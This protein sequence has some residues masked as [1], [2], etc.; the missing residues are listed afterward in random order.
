MIA[1]LVL[2][3]LAVSAAAG[4]FAR[5]FGYDPEN[6]TKCLQS[7]I[8]SGARTVIVDAAPGT[9]FIEPIRLRSDLE[10]V[11]GEGVT[12]RAVPGA[13]K[14]IYSMMFRGD[15]VTNVTI[16]GERGATLSMLKRD[17]LDAERYR[18]S[19]WRHMLAFYDSGRIAVSN[20]T[21]S[22]SGGDG[23]Y[24]ARCRDVRI[25]N[26]L[27]TGHDR[28]GI[29]VIGAENLYVG[30]SRFCATAGTPPACGI[31]FE[32]NKETECFVSNVIEDCTFDG[33]ESCGVCFHIPHFGPQT[34]PLGVTLRDCRFTGNASWGFRLYASWGDPGVA[35]T[36]RVEN[37]LFATNRAGVCWIGGM[38]SDSLKVAFSGC[39]F[40]HRGVAGPAIVFD[41][42]ESPFDFGGVSFE[43][44]RLLADT[45]DVFQFLGYTGDGVTNVFGTV[46]VCLPSGDVRCL[47]MEKVSLM[48]P[49]DPA[50]RAF[51]AATVQRKL[52]HP[53]ADRLKG[54]ARPVF[55]R[56]RQFFVQSA[57]DPGE[58]RLRFH[59]RRFGANPYRPEVTIHDKVGTLVGK[60]TLAEDVTEYVLKTTVPG[61]THTFTVNSRGNLCAVESD[62]AGHGILADSR[63]QIAD[64]AGRDLHFSVPAGSRQVKVELLA[65]KGTGL[66]VRILD[67]AGKVR[68]ET[69]KT[70]AG[71]ILT[72]D[73]EPTAGP[74]IW[75]LAVLAMERPFEL[76]LGGDVTAVV[77]ESPAA[78]LE[79]RRLTHPVR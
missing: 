56:G 58:R 24:I 10:L 55:C 45:E 62:A 67:A 52:L 23:V 4:E 46:E 79:T 3:A 74:E 69:V 73:R 34:R 12:V 16:R 57:P 7:A 50:A 37:C 38:P 29:S 9:W 36:I 42:G 20:L 59:C 19:E 77:S 40:D 27:A 22:A 48:Y 44:T 1:G 33:N 66:S 41:N 49:P 21:L 71:R 61:N 25:E 70:D 53:V 5:D 18:W 65:K 39:T 78:C 31:D 68:A 60:L 17:Y 32:P 6:A 43:R 72:V 35:G 28:Q 8:D 51:R 54:T 75:T 11:F 47:S 14:G 26:V 30:H 15:G 76:R 2:A 63:V 13:Y 64:A